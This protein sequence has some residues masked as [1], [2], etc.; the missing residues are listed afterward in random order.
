MKTGV[1]NIDMHLF[2]ERG[3]LLE[4]YGSEKSGKTALSLSIARETIL[5]DEAACVIHTDGIPDPVYFRNACSSSDLLIVTPTTGETILDCAFVLLQNGVRT[6][7]VDNATNVFASDDLEV[8]NDWVT[9][10]YRMWYNSLRFLREEA[11]KRGA[12]VALLT[13]MRHDIATGKMVSSLHRVTSSFCPVRIRLQ[14]K[15][16]ENMY[17]SLAKSTSAATVETSSGKAAPTTVT[18]FPSCGVDRNLELLKAL[19]DRRVALK[20][21]AFVTICGTKLRGVSAAS[22]YVSENYDTLYTL[23]R[24]TFERATKLGSN[25]LEGSSLSTA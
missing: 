10:T 19:V 18:F 1:P 12:T 6:V 24:S 9:P 3:G 11:R 14:H 13:Q 25:R 17:G 2:K 16:S 20:T 21:G 4:I 23:W 15:T 5:Q 7:I 22:N 8:G